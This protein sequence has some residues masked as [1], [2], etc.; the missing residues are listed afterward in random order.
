MTASG[1][2]MV[3]RVARIINERANKDYNA[4]MLGRVESF[5]IARAVIEG[6]REATDAMYAAEVECYNE[7]TRKKVTRVGP[8]LWEAMIDSAL[9][10]SQT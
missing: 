7:L 4:Y 1:N 10:E 6:M 8:A 5:A 3:E 2:E 9:S